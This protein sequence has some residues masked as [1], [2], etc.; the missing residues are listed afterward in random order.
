MLMFMSR[1]LFE[2]AMSPWPFRVV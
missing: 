1:V 2:I